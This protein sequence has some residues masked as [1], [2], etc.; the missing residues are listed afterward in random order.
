[1][2]FVLLVALFLPPLASCGPGAARPRKGEVLA[3]WEGAHRGRFV[4]RMSASLCAESG[5]AEL[6]AVRGDTGVG[7]VLLPVDSAQLASGSDQ[8]V[9]PTTLEPLRPAAGAA[10]RW[11]TGA[12][13]VAFEGIAGT[14]ELTV[15]EDSALSGTIDVRMQQLSATDSLVMTGRFVSLALERLPAGCSETSRRNIR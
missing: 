4:A 6:V 13:F 8:V 14:V 11:F 2:R 5:T 1:M 15:Q 12:D 9:V 10:L 7:F 3:Q